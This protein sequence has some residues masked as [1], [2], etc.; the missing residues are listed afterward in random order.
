M[1]RPKWPIDRKTG[2]PIK[3]IRRLRS[4]KRRG[5][6]MTLKDLLRWT[7]YH[8]HIRQARDTIVTVKSHKKLKNGG[9]RFRTRTEF[10]LE[11][12]YHRSWVYFPK[13]IDEGIKISRSKSI[14]VSC[15]CSS[16]KYRAEMALW[17][18][19]AAEVYWSNGQMPY[20]TNPR[21]VPT[22]CKHLY[23]DM[24]YIKKHRL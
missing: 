24:K 20:I 17:Y 19:G 6:Q 22:L 3:P 15:D 9:Y 18:H 11:S 2:L 8:P 13:T 7:L 12:K 16:F 10:P 14:L 5:D 23:M 21:L 4:L 1:A